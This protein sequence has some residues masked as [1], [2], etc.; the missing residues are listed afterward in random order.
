MER[1]GILARAGCCI[2][3]EEKIR[4]RIVELEAERDRFAQQADAQMLAY[5]AV[6]GELQQL[7]QSDEEEE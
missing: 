4:G 5:S 2:E 7:L 1:G 6:I 3:M